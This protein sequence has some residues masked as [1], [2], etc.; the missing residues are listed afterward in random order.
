MED[1]D[2][3]DAEQFILQIL[4]IG[5][6]A[7]FAMTEIA[8]ISLSPTKL[9][10]MADDG[11]GS[12]SRLL[13][14]VEEPSGFLS[15]IQIGITLAGFLGSAFAADNFSGYLVSW[16]YEDLGYK[17][18]SISTLDTLAVILITLILSYFTLIF[19]E[20]VPKR[21]AMQKPMEVAKISC[22]IVSG[23]AVIMKPIVWFLSFSTNIVLKIF[24]F[25][26]EAEEE[27]ITEEEIRMMVDLGEEKG[28]IDTDEGE[29]I[30]NV[31][32]FGE[33][34][35]YDIMTH[36]TDMITLSVHSKPEDILHVVRESGLSRFPV[37]DK[38]IDDIVGIL[39][40]RDFLI[41]LADHKNENLK[42]N[43]LMRSPYFVPE[44]ICASLLFKDMQT[45]KIH[46]AVVIDEYG[47]TSGIV[48]MEDLLEEIVG[49][50]YDEFDPAQRPLVERVGDNLWKVSGRTDLKTLSEALDM[51]LKESPDYDT[52]GGLILNHLQFIPDDGS[53]LDL[54]AE[55]LL[56]HVE[57]ISGRRIQTA[58]VEKQK[59]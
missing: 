9:K 47:Q 52:L 13:K 40:T 57:I 12:A 26:T 31:F 35:A 55:G 45:K 36:S 22:R 11:D 5:L 56:I 48:T 3:S 50:I 25:K 53:Q 18:L 20:L 21:I 33:R 58:F 23:L 30:D 43:Q 44:T 6:N 15:T 38:D 28:T 4:L 49:N 14:L 54:E 42:I 39:N 37:F 46:I 24:H 16:I 10:K 17:S 8:V 29:W 51:E 1:A 32:D 59:P 41:A 27:S 34:T 7:F 2:D 19:G